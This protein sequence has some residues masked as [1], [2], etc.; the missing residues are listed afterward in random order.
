MGRTLAA[1]SSVLVDDTGADV[2][3]FTE[4]SVGTAVEMDIFIF[5]VGVMVESVLFVVV[6]TVGVLTNNGDKDGI[7][8]VFQ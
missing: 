5:V 2:V 3:V 7:S 4:A 1:F 8:D 6:G